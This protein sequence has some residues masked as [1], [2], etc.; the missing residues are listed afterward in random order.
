MDLKLK[1][2]L[3]IILMFHLH[4]EKPYKCERCNSAFSQAAHLKNHEKVH[5]GNYSFKSMTLNRVL[6]SSIKS[7]QALNHINVIFALEALATSLL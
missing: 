6:I 7:N 3:I 2:S 5:L 4:R 1:I